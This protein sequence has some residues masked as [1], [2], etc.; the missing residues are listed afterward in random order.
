MVAAAANATPGVNDVEQP[1]IAPD[2]F[3]M[4]K[5]LNALLLVMVPESV[6]VAAPFSVTVPLLCV[7]VPL[8]V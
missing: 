5:L 2:V 4:F 6:C 8:L 1:L 3:V 7:N